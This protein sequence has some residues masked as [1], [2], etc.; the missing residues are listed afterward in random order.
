[1]QQWRQ[2]EHGEAAGQAFADL[3]VLEHEGG[4]D[5]V[6]RLGRVQ[7]G[8]RGAV[9]TP[10]VQRLPWSSGA[11]VSFFTAVL[12]KGKCAYQTAAARARKP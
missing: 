4:L 12:T 2:D 10:L 9:R 5:R 3:E 11:D 6:Q 1:M 8:G 7:Q